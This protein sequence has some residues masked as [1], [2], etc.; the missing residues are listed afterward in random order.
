MQKDY[1]ARD[2]KDQ[3]DSGDDFYT[4]LGVDPK[5]SQQ[6]IQKAYRKKAKEM[7]ADKT[8]G[9]QQETTGKFSQAHED[10][11]RLNRAY[12]VL[13]DSE[14]RA[15]YDNDLRDAKAFRAE[16]KRRAERKEAPRGSAQDRKNERAER[17]E[18]EERHEAPRGSAQNRRAWTEN[19]ETWQTTSRVDRRYY[20]F[21]M[22][23]AKRRP[24]RFYNDLRDFD[25]SR[26]YDGPSHGFGDGFVFYDRARKPAWVQRLLK[27]Y[28]FAYTKG[29]MDPALVREFVDAAEKGTLKDY[30]LINEKGDPIAKLDQLPREYLE[31]MHRIVHAEAKENEFGY[32]KNTLAATRIEHAIKAQKYAERI[33]QQ[34]QRTTYNNQNRRSG[35]SY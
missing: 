25:F 8:Q 27:A 9:A 4:A 26:N 2:I 10:M 16:Q 20:D 6:E 22:K 30:F 35:P 15:E 31:N 13:K 24:S 5:A 21:Q 34:K 7:H 1:T 33:A 14:K 19:R 17:K 12:D 23:S 18:K 29:V 32:G 11:V 3:V 28:T